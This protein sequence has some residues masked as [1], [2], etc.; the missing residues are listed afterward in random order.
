MEK[1]IETEKCVSCGIDTKIPVSLNVEVRSYYVE[2]A[3]Q[4]CRDCY[5][6]TFDKQ[7]KNDT[8]SKK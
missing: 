1:N 8:Q 6:K 2:G 7:E 4:L 5:K 3:G